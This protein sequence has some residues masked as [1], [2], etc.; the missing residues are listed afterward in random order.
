VPH[1]DDLPP[2]DDSPAAVADPMAT[3]KIRA[4]QPRESLA[5]RVADA[6]VAQ[7]LL[8]DTLPD[9]ERPKPDDRV[10]LVGLV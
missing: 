10:L 1:G 7:L 9:D 6:A 5:A 8:F 3:L 2:A 4:P